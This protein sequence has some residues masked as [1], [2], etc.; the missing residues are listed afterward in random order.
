MFQTFLLFR[1]C[2]Q[3]GHRQLRPRRPSS[4]V[5]AVRQLV[6]W[7]VGSAGSLQNLA[8]WEPLR[9]RVVHPGRLGQGQQT[10][11]P[12]EAP[13]SPPQGQT[14]LKSPLKIDDIILHMLCL[15]QLV[16]FKMLPQKEFADFSSF[17]F[18][19]R[20]IFTLHVS[21][22]SFRNYSNAILHF[23]SIYHRRLII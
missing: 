14:G 6:G 21:V 15:A 17:S 19:I 5:L 3:L 23:C 12:A 22:H 13:S 11:T 4:E 18:E 1:A 8:R 7:G 9:G 2:F 16:L 20:E 10:A